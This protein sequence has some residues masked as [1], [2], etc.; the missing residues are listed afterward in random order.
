MAGKME[1]HAFVKIFQQQAGSQNLNSCKETIECE[2]LKREIQYCKQT[3]IF[4]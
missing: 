4:L 1:K 2:F 3:F